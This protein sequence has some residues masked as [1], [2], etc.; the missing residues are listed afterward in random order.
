MPFLTVLETLISVIK[1]QADPQSTEG[2]IPDSQTALLVLYPHTADSGDRSSLSCLYLKGHW[3]ISRRLHPHDL[4]TFQRPTFKSYLIGDSDLTHNF[5]RGHEDS[6]YPARRTIQNEMNRLKGSEHVWQGSIWD[7]QF[8][9]INL[10][11]WFNYRVHH[12]TVQMAFNYTGTLT[13]RFIFLNPT[14]KITV[15]IS[16]PFR[17]RNVGHFNKFQCWFCVF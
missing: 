17:F 16:F 9:F 12:Q 13:S 5:F 7:I 2:P 11:N 8:M 4:I 1:A 14:N 15:V 6:D 10:I 3:R